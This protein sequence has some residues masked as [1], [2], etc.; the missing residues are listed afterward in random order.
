MARQFSGS[1]R[2]RAGMRADTC[3]SLRQ[4][5]PHL[6]HARPSVGV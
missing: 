2:P 4:P 3:R 1:H 6:Y 5:R